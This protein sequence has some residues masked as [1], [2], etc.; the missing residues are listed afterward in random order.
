MTVCEWWWDG[1]VASTDL[2]RLDRAI[3]RRCLDMP[4]R[5]IGQGDGPVTGASIEDRL[6]L[7][8]YEGTEQVGLVNASIDSW[9]G[10]AFV[11]IV[12]PGGR[13]AVSL[14]RWLAEVARSHPR[15]GG[16]RLEF[17]VSGVYRRERAEGCRRTWRS[18]PS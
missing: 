4:S 17:S 11:R 15:L 10:S 2:E 8:V 9:D 1:Y 3:T 14:C 18:R 6:L 12:V 5:C 16:T 7:G 13:R